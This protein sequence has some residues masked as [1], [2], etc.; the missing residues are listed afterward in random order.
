MLPRISQLLNRLGEGWQDLGLGES[1]HVAPVNQLGP[2]P[3]TKS[4]LRALADWVP[5]TGLRPNDMAAAPWEV[6]TEV[7]CGFLRCREPN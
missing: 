3:A 6:Q 7:T 4:T 5:V 1:H 2:G